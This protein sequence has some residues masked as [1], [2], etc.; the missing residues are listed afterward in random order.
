MDHAEFAGKTVLITGAAGGIGRATALAFARLG[1][2]LVLGDAN[3]A[4]LQETEILVRAEG[5]DAIGQI[6]NVAVE[7]DA[8]SLVAQAV[9]HFGRLDHAFNNAGVTTYIETWDTDAWGRVLGINLNGVMFGLKHQIAQ[10][11]AQREAGGTGGTIVN[12]ASIAGLSGAGTAEYVASK[13]AVVGLSRAAGVRYAP[14]G[15]R[16][17]AVCPGVIETAMTQPLLE[18]DDIRPMV[19]AMCPIGRAGRADEVADAVVFLSSSRASFI[20]G[21]ALAV[22][23]G[24]M[25]R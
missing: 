6:C 10:F 16:V 9:Q 1:A 19:L 11:L 23:G 15:I 20:A 25:A 12:T 21:H 22:D 18:N 13:H 17:N 5:A 4:G 14:L 7:A 2:R 24:Y 3:G 8:V